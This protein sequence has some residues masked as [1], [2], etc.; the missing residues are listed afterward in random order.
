MKTWQLSAIF[1]LAG[2]LLLALLSALE[3]A[4][5]MPASI[6][7]QPADFAAQE[8]PLAPGAGQDNVSP[9]SSALDWTPTVPIV[10][11]LARPVPVAPGPDLAP[12]EGAAPPLA[13][14]ARAAALRARGAGLNSTSEGPAESGIQGASPTGW[15]E[16][17]T[18][19]VRQTWNTFH[20]TGTG[21]WIG[22]LDSGVDFGNPA[23]N[24]RYA[25][26]PATPTGTQA[27]LGWPIAF[28][29]LSIEEF[30]AEPGRVWP[31]NWEHF[32]NASYAI[33]GTGLFTFSDPG[34]PAAVYTAP[35][36]SQSGR[37]WLGYHPDRLLEA[38]VLAADEVIS[39]SYDAA[40]LDL[41]FDGWFET[42]VDRERPVGVL[43]LTGDGVPDI[44][45]GLLYWIADGTHRPPGMDAVYGTGGPVPAAGTL[46]AFMVDDAQSSGGG[47]G[48]RC[49][50]TAVGDDGGQFVPL[51]SVASF[52][53]STY[54]P[55]VQ[56]PAPGARIIAMGNYYE[57]GA[58]EAWYD[59]TVLGY[60]GAPGTGD[61]PQLVTLSYGEGG[62]ENDGW[63]WESRYLTHLNLAY[64]DAS[65]LYLHSAGN[66]GPGY[67]TTLSPYP[68]TAL[69]VG[70]STQYGTVNQ[71]GI[72]E[73]VGLPERVNW[74]DVARFSGRGPGADGKGAIDL[75]ANGRYGTGANPLN[76]AAEGSVAYTHWS[77]TSRS[78]PDAAGIAALAYQAFYQAQGRFPSYQEGAQ[79][80]MNAATDLGYDPLVQGAGSAHAYRA[81]QTA[82]GHYG[83]SVSPPR[84]D[85]GA[86][87]GEQYPAFA[88]GLARGETGRVTFTVQNPAAVPVTVTLGAV[89]LGEIARYTATLPTITDTASN[90]GHGAPDYALD[91][92][93]WITQHPE[94]DLMVVKMRV[95]FEHFDTLPPTP[96]ASR[97]WWWLVLYNWWD[98]HDDNLWWSDLD[99][100]G[101]VDWPGEL[102]G[103]DQ[104]MR[105]DYSPLEATQQELRVAHPYARS[106]GAGSG[107]IWA[108]AAHYRRSAG[109]NRTALQFEVLFYSQIPWDDL[110]LSTGQL[111]LPAGGQITFQAT[112]PVPADAPYGFYQGTVVLTD[113]GRTDVDPLYTSRQVNIP[114]T[115]QVW[116][117]LSAGARIGGS[118]A[119]GRLYENGWVGTGFDWYRYPEAGDWRFFGFDLVDPPPGSA[120]LVHT[121]W[122]DYPTDLDTLIFGPV[123]DPFS[124]AN[125]EGFGPY[126]LDWV[127]GSA[128]V[129]DPPDWEFDTATGGT[130]EWAA[131]PAQDG[132][133][134]LAQ[135]SVLLGGH[136]SA[137]P[138]T[139]E[140]GLAAVSPYPVWVDVSADPLPGIALAFQ[141]GIAISGGLTRTHGFAW[142]APVGVVGVISPEAVVVHP[143]TLTQA[144]YRLD[145]F[146]QTAQGLSQLDLA[147][148]DDSGSLAGEW[149]PQDQELARSSGLGL[150]ERLAVYSLDPGPHWIVAGGSDGSGHY[151]LQA[152]SYARDS[153]GGLLFGMLP[154][155]I[156]PHQVYTLEVTAAEMPERGESGLLVL[157]TPYLTDLL[158][159]PVYA[160]ALTDLWVAKSGPNS[161][162]PGELISYLIQYGNRGPSPASEVCLSDR[163]PI[164]L[165]P[166]GP[167]SLTVESLAAGI[168]Q[169]WVLTAM[170]GSGPPP[171]TVL[172]NTVSI[173]GRER[174]PES[175]DNLA[176]SRA[177]LDWYSLW[178]PLIMIQ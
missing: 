109:D 164:H 100:D 29:A 62:I 60:D 175:G 51:A 154:G 38:L 59:F 77:G 124:A 160:D 136:Q 27:Y 156:A 36:T 48:T 85:A 7:P 80:M 137:V 49:A 114:F 21:V 65:P 170:V 108:G 26:Q 90:Y 146:F 158:E 153:D 119:G 76:S 56:G 93:P 102:D 83:I 106:L 157:G 171:G 55:L 128:R 135:Q 99:D 173:A 169:T 32:V 89:R 12:A 177:V 14:A 54:G 67:G 57:G 145:V 81:V 94:A 52:Y 78:A 143:L 75:V 86:Y 39:G 110:S 71:W 95:P 134:I 68:A 79:L 120:V 174:D 70:A 50:S 37:Y 161:M 123:P 151:T 113:A 33:T 19:G 162:L 178:L 41:D 73:T 30:I 116:P 107:G 115:W 127:G 24:G 131:A 63:D 23:L 159:I 61:E 40:Y 149:D 167:L 122:Q 45:S 132:L 18:Q 105:F 13:G 31:E 43:D 22:V 46:L 25:V 168:S 129:G 103:G 101:R 28:D 35:G 91:L 82:L 152:T 96:Q 92:T 47:H 104:W 118:P 117:D 42:R 72:S 172:T 1:F 144:S 138:F 84:V 163:L 150:E 66:G 20:I 126:A 3:A 69:I 111:R 130:E 88:G 165:A 17:D 141:S 140:L 74:G 112:I 98:D 176:Q 133:H 166:V 8:D 142:A 44:S 121:L 58:L 53:T 155:D 64:G 139:A 125:P 16:N 15:Y 34:S 97:N 10:G 11:R 6:R 147:L 4:A 5:E 9:A 2:M 87:R 148:Y